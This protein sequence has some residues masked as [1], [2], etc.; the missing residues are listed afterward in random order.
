[1]TYTG[2]FN[3][4]YQICTCIATEKPYQM[5]WKNDDKHTTYL[6]TMYLF[7][8]MASA[9]VRTTQPAVPCSYLLYIAVTFL[10]RDTS[11][12]MV[13]WIGGFII[14]QWWCVV[15]GY[16]PGGW[17]RLYG[18]MWLDSFLASCGSG[19]VWRCCMG[20]AGAS[21]NQPALLHNWFLEMSLFLVEA[22]LRAFPRLP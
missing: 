20:H 4:Y 1:M 18:L 5:F 11:S 10:V 16:L 3:K 17:W 9:N 13:R 14:R 7:L 22:T 6:L 21:S 19:V 12:K 8:N 2:L 15:L